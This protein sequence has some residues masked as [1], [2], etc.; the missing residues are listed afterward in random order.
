VSRAVALD[1]EAIQALWSD[2]PPK[3]RAVLAHI[4]AM[5]QPPAGA[6]RTVGKIVVPTAA[7]VEAGTPSPRELKTALG[8]LRVHHDVFDR[9]AA[10]QAC[11][12]D[13]QLDLSVTDR[14]VGVAALRSGDDVVVLTSDPGDITAITGPRATVLR[15]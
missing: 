10:E 5:L 14:H 6:R 4:E 7:M 2:R 9:D 15:V 13:S 11:R 12:L 8:R 1:S 3:R